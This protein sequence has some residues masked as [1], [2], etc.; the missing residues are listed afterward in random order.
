MILL[1]LEE[2]NKQIE[3]R[4]A[5]VHEQSAVQRTVGTIWLWPGATT[6]VI[7]GLWPE[8]HAMGHPCRS[9]CAR[10]VVVGAYDQ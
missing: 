5:T 1:H 2:A 8:T 9:R 6:I 4:G 3:Q 10:T 7:G